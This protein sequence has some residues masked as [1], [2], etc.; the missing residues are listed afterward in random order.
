MIKNK[1]DKNKM[2]NNKLNFNRRGTIILPLNKNLS[3][4]LINNQHNY[5]KKLIASSVRK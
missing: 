2:S 5:S 3:E 4:N 1:E